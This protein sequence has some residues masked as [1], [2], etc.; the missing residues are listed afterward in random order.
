M[1]VAIL[2]FAGLAFFVVA[3]VMWIASLV[4]FTKEDGRC[5]ETECSICPFPCKNHTINKEESD[6]ES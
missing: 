5:D 4:T 2:K 3:N 6:N 1:L